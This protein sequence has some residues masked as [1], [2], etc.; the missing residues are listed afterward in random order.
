MSRGPRSATARRSWG[1]DDTGCT[2]L[3]VDMDAFFA[4]V[5]LLDHPEL[6]GRPLI[7][8]GEHRGV[9]AAAS[10][11]ARAFGVHSAM[12]TARARALCPQA[13]VL[14]GRHHRYA[15][16]SRQVMA[17][18]AEVTPVLEQVSVDE[19]FLDVA[20]AVRR[21]GPPVTIARWIRAQVRE[22]TGVPA[23]VG[24][25]TTKHVAKLASTH[26][27]PDGL[28][29]VP[30]AQT[31]PFLHS[32]PVGA[33]WGVGEKTREVLE[34]R[35]WDT[36]ADIAAT[37]LPVLHRAVGVAAGQRLHELAWGIDPRPVR[38]G[39]AEKSVGTETTFAVDVID[40][41]AL[42]TVLLDQAHQCAA[43]LRQGGL[44]AGG[45]AIKVRR[46]DFTTLTRSRALPAPT[47][48]AHDLHVAARALLAAVEIPAAGVRL[49]GLRAERLVGADDGV[50]ATLDED[51]HRA[52]AERAMDGVRARFGPQLLRPASLLGAGRTDPVGGR[53]PGPAQWP[54]PAS[55]PASPDLS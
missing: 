30:A 48:L 33:L 9:V 43:R 6:R 28:L 34:R 29:L 8:G 17:V 40:R 7:V 27:K 2:V 13:V 50:Q 44:R 52:R 3:H 55:E 36:V 37:P 25:A 31:V 32:L 18:L 22:R 12:P 49:L 5:E 38:P 14:P 20:G 42:E 39:R 21:M 24:V 45:V 51:P 23:S 26:A 53:R 47:D 35:G 16:V 41:A 1:E 4:S 19:A 10:Y 11:E 46:P 15:E 54:A